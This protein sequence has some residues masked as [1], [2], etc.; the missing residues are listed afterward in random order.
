MRRIVHYSCLRLSELEINKID[1][2][3]PYIC[4]LCNH[5]LLFQYNDDI[6]DLIPL[7][8]QLECGKNN[9][10]DSDTTNNKVN[11]TLK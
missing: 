2:D 6:E 1:P 4:D 3:V 11:K 8:N 7:P 10:L 5:E 9:T